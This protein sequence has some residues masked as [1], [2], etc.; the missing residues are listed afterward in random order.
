MLAGR[1][2]R[3]FTKLGESSPRD[4]GAKSGGFQTNVATKMQVHKTAIEFF[5]RKPSN[6]V[7]IILCNVP[8]SE[9][10]ID[11]GTRGDKGI[12]TGRDKSVT[13]IEMT[14]DPRAQCS[15]KVSSVNVHGVCACET[16][17]VEVMK[18]ASQRAVAVS[19]LLAV[20]TDVG[21]G[22]TTATAGSSDP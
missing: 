3:S 13:Y 14:V 15:G 9:K 12:V 22:G 17:E 11:K 18:N 2:R 8:G 7:D 4:E 20:C 6:Y 21:V 5:K 1:R 16:K 19:K 10:G